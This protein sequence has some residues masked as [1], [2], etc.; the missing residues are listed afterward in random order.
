MRPFPLPPRALIAHRGASADAPENTLA[1]IRLA[2]EQR[3]DGIEVDLQLTADHRL[4][5][6]HDRDLSHLAGVKLQVEQTAFDELRALNVAAHFRAEARMPTVEELFH[7]VPPDLPLNLELKR[8]EAPRERYIEALQRAIGHREHILVSSFD[9]ELLAIA[10]DAM[11]SLPLAPLFHAVGEAIVEQELLDRIA[12]LSDLD[13]STL[14]VNAEIATPRILAAAA[15]HDLSVLVYTID[16]PAT[17][18]TLFDRGVAGV[19]TNQP[20][21]MRNR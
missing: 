11:P 19:F 1:A 3:A 21:N 4:V 9:H 8:W 15:A 6:V 20:G 2:V 5:I 13:P 7:A 10:R 16:D 17:A 18:A 14:H 12:A